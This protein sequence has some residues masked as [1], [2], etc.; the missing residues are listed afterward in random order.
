MCHSSV[1]LESLEFLGRFLQTYTFKDAVR[2]I[3]D[4]RRF[5]LLVSVLDI[6]LLLL[7]MFSA[8]ATLL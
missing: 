6:L 4:S 1:F 8:F 2:I 7:Q 5:L 3:W